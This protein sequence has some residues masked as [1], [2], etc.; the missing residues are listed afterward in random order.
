MQPSRLIQSTGT[1]AHA[2]E[3]LDPRL[4][5]WLEQVV[6]PRLGGTRARDLRVSRI[7]TSPRVWKGALSEGETEVARFVLKVAPE[8]RRSE[9]PVLHEIEMNGLLHDH[10]AAEGRPECVSER[11]AWRET[12]PV[13][14]AL[15]FVAGPD[16]ASLLK[17]AASGDE[18]RLAVA[19]QALEKVASLLRV[20]HAM[21]PGGVPPRRPEPAEYA[22]R[23]LRDAAGVGVASRSMLL[24][25]ERALEP[26]R[27]VLETRAVAVV[28]GDANATNFLL[29]ESGAVA[30]DLERVGL[31]DSALDLG[32][33]AA[34]ILHLVH[35]YGGDRERSKRLLQALFG[36]YGHANDAD[37]GLRVGVYTAM[38]LW[39]VAR[40]RWVPRRHRRKLMTLSQLALADE[41]LRRLL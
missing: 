15:G 29:A 18:A 26:L 11:L 25:L 31:Y 36:A 39:R 4:Q 1:L 34:E 12:S 14:L 38:G 5:D 35:Q 23:L 7:S 41:R 9:E 6:V 2:K 30:I 20:L 8:G 22:E 33:V 28:H 32:F 37:F 24:S 21:P 19:E 3:R 40:N 17:D 16:L 13:A 10:F 27:P